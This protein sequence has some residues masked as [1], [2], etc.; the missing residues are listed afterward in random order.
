MIRVDCDL[1]TELLQGHCC[2]DDKAL[3]ATYAKVGVE[4]DNGPG[5]GLGDGGCGWR[6]LESYFV[7]R[8][9]VRRFYPIFEEHNVEL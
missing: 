9:G 1:V 5:F 7:P 4:E 2:I 6:H 8:I 3:G